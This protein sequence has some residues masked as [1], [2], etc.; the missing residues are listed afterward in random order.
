MSFAIRLVPEPVRSLGFGSIGAAYMGIGTAMTEPVRIFHLQNL[1]DT[2]LM[3]SFGG[4]DDHVAIPAGG[5]LLIDI[6][7]NKSNERGFFLGEGERLYVKEI[8]TP[9]LGAVYLTTFY[10]TT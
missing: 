9:T 5:Y 3:F 8:A 1:T 4:I 2:L 7:A 10:G 6:T